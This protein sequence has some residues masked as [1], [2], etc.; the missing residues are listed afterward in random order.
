MTTPATESLQQV[1]EQNRITRAIELEDV[2]QNPEP[3]KPVLPEEIATRAERGWDLHLTKRQLITKIGEGTYTV[4]ASNGGT[5]TVHYGGEAEDCEC[6]DFYVHHGEIACK[7]L[8]AVALLFA[9]RR[10]PRCSC[11]GGYVTITV[12]EDD[13]ERDEAAPCRKCVAG[14]EA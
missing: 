10:R 11:F 9:A 5:H 8:T 13:Q 6:V 4:P 12:E 14:E 7:H 3:A 1:A 2:I